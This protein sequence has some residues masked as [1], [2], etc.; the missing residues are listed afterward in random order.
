MYCVPVL[1]QIALMIVSA[2]RIGGRCPSPLLCS[3]AHQETITVTKPIELFK[4]SYMKLLSKLPVKITLLTLMFTMLGV[5]LVGYM[6]LLS[7]EKLLREQAFSNIEHQLRQKSN[8]YMIHL[9]ELQHTLLTLSESDA[10]TQIFSSTKSFENSRKKPPLEQYEHLANHFMTI[11]KHQPTYMQMRLFELAQ[12]TQNRQGRIIVQV[13]RKADGQI[14]QIAKETLQEEAELP[15]FQQAIQRSPTQFYISDIIHNQREKN[16]HEQPEFHMVVPVF[17]GDHTLSGFLIVHVDFHTLTNALFHATDIPHLFMA[18]DRGDYLYNSKKIHKTK[19]LDI[20]QTQ[21]IRQDFPNV[22]FSPTTAPAAHDQKTSFLPQHHK[23]SIFAT[24][25]TQVDMPTH[26]VEIVFQHIYFDPLDATRHLLLVAIISSEA[27]AQRFQHYWRDLLTLSLAVALC[28][29][30]LIV[31]TIQRLTRPIR[32]LTNTIHRIASGEENVRLP[33]AGTDE[34]GALTI[35]FQTMLENLSDSNIALQ[36]L[37]T[38]LEEQVRERTTDL[39]VVRDQAL[40]ASQ[41]K[42]SF[43]ATMS[44]E[45]RT[46]MNVILGMLELLRTSE[47]SLPDRERVELAFS[48][49]ETLLTLIN[50]ILDFS[51]IEAQ[52]ITLDKVDFDLRRLV[53]EAAMTVAPLAHAKEIE[54]TAFFPDVPFTAVRGDPVRLKQIFTN[55]LG[56]AIKFTAEGGSVE[57]H[58]GPTNSDEKHID[59]LFEVRDSGIGVAHGDRE[60]IFNQFTQADSSSTRCHEGSGLGLS[61]CKHLVQIM[62]GEIDVETNPYTNSGSVFCF[63]VQLNKQ[64][65][66]YIQNAKE[67][68]YKNLR[69][70]AMANDGLQRTLVE[71]VLIPRGARLDHVAEM[72]TVT[73]ILR[74]A[75]T[76]GQPY[77]LVLFNQR[78][79]KSNR[80]EFRQLLEFNEELRFI[81]MTDLLDQGWDQATELPGTAICLKKPINAERLHAAIEWLIKNKGCHQKPQ[82]TTA[83]QEEDNLYCS[84]SILVVDDQQ[85]NLTVTRGMLIRIGCRPEQISTAE[86]GREAV[87]I[88][89]EKNVAL[90]LMDCQ[91]PVMDGFDAT[92]AIHKWEKE[93]GRKPVPIVAFT[94]DIT[95][96]SQDNIRSCGMDG[97]LSKPVSMAHLRNQLV[98]FSLLKPREPGMQTTPQDIKEAPSAPP[99][100]APKQIDMKALLKSMRSIGLQAE[101]F[102]EVADLLS[103]QFLELLNAM[104]RDFEKHD[105][106]SARATAHVVKGSMAN[107]IFPILQKSTRTLYETVREEKWGEARKELDRVKKLF[108]PI[109]EA[110]LAFLAKDNDG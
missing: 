24:T 3:L 89:Q 27:V 61:I 100:H 57:L 43:L 107:T 65:K 95:P 62:K 109:Q 37:A 2:M 76:A 101:D 77:Q 20:D 14:I 54:L 69:V 46:P 51:K 55:L 84:G 110:L 106:Q 30:F 42:S 102:R 16:R 74:Q 50:N 21:N 19:D 4:K 60:K 29:S 67:Q 33:P 52:Q 47:I 83:S 82:T 105:Y 56:N 103:A 10:V 70:L 49:G 13:D 38:S 72:E 12:N 59:L 31:L 44:H 68:D 66:P 11:L 8:Q 99:T 92:R 63:T 32:K 79:G 58:G 104:Q 40:A 85:A 15:Y 64:Q 41:A 94:A 28:L 17:T 6:S 23:S 73:E 22:D 25:P 7:T 78:P 48:S 18:T 36:N 35:A 1:R 88:F 26:E 34:V 45:I 93:M 87:A 96:K 53:Y 80:R 98:Q 90:V 86:N 75:E 97:F 108:M 81:M 9:N 5:I 91:M 39:A 71:E